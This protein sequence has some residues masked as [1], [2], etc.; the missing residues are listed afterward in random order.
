MSAITDG[1]NEALVLGDHLLGS[2]LAWRSPLP[3]LEPACFFASEL[4]QDLWAAILV[5]G[6]RPD[7]ALLVHHL[8]RDLWERAEVNIRQ[9]IVN[10]EADVP[11]VSGQ[12]RRAARLR[13]LFEQHELSRWTVRLNEALR[14]GDDIE[15]AMVLEQQPRQETAVPVEAETVEAFLNREAASE[16]EWVIPGLLRRGW[17]CVVVAREGQGKATLLR[18][19]A[20]AAAAGV[21]P[22]TFK[23]I[24]PIKT[25]WLDFEN[26]ED[27]I[28]SQLRL[29]L[30]PLPGIPLAWQWRQPAGLDLR[31]RRHRN[32]VA[33]LL[34]QTK[35]DLVC[36]GPL[37]KAYRSK[38]GESYEEVAVEVA[39]ALDDLRTRYG[40]SILIEH[41]AA[42]GEKEPRGS[43]VWMGWPDLGFFLEPTRHGSPDLMVTRFRGDRGENSWPDEL[44]RG[45]EWPWE[46]R[47]NTTQPF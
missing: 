8:D 9:H 16:A 41:H 27:V 32:D 12:E 28:T 33:R 44:V 45:R 18:Q 19:I 25:L 34:D 31:L 23:Q 42:K 39:N 5:E 14:A 7:P 2:A 37:Y 43:A 3:N 4:Q 21:H 36:L 38:T 15:V 26:P 40:F 6:S 35:P 46:G 47:W 17:R 24:V 10:L 11:S 13:Q 29:A 1:H 20:M 22:F 30:R